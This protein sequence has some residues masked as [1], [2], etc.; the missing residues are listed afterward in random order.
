MNKAESKYFNTAL[1]MNQAFLILLEKK[2]I[3]YITVTE[4]CKYAEV[5]RSTFYLHYE[6]IG[7]LLNE[8][9][10]YMFDRF[11]TYFPDKDINIV[12]D[13]KNA[14]LNDLY[15]ITPKLLKPYLTFI[16]EHKKLFA[17]TLSRSS[18]L[19]LNEIYDKIFTNIL[20][21]ILDRFGIPEK[22]K[23]YMLEFYIH[24]IIAVITEWLT[25]DCEDSIDYIIDIISEQIPKLK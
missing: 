20:S 4:I 14:N 2:D 24:G 18:S 7:D 12:N 5:N 8:S 1:K 9:V 6:N 23:K 13:I 16:F 17:T 11:L 3:E 21:R 10:Q 19:R 15:L 25:N 22:R